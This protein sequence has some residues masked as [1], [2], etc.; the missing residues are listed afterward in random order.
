MALVND[1]YN[2]RREH[3]RINDTIFLDYMPV[4]HA[5]A[6]EMGNNIT[7]PSADNNQKEVQLRTLQTAFTM[8]TDQINHYD[9]EVA[10]ALRLL[11]DKINLISRDFQSHQEEAEKN[12]KAIEVNLSG[13]GIAFLTAD[14][15]EARTP[16]TVQMEL[17]P[18]GVIID[19]I[20]NVISCT[21]S[22]SDKAKASFHIRLAF[23]YMNETDRNLLI[24][25]IL[26]RQAEELRNSNSKL[27]PK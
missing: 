20:A 1:S 13:G 5:T 18:S 24:K 3:F 14:P 7:N 8:V 27:N 10:R 2:E 11:N 19:T 15:I 22:H 16:L 12:T 23:A 25:H 17:N 26:S 21:K 9:R 4:D 6:Q